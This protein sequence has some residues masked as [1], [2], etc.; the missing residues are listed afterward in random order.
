[1]HDIYAE[2]N[3]V[4]IFPT[5]QIDISR[6]PGKVENVN[7]NADCF[8]DEIL[9]RAVFSWSYEEMSGID[10]R[11]VE[12]KIKTYPDAKP[13]RQCLRAANPR[14]APT[15]KAKVEKLLNVGFIYLVSLT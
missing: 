1:M 5:I 15:I 12:H 11:I 6:T 13:V 8:P 7:I 9:F 3:M 2:G 14:K 4:S 10:P